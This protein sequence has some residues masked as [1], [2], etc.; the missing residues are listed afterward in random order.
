MTGNEDV[1][2]QIEKQIKMQKAVWYIVLLSFLAFIITILYWFFE[3]DP[4]SVERVAGASTWSKCENRQYSFIRVVKS[5]KAVDIFVQE[6]WHDMDD[7]QDVGTIES[8][9]VISKVIHYPLDAGFEKAMTFNKVVPINVPIGRYEYRPYA[10]Y[11]V[12][13]L[14]RVTKPLPI[15]N[16]DVVCDYDKDKH[17]EVY[18]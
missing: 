9:L 3:P 15:Q 6:R 14:K 1:V 11:Q 8:E 10:S 7:M 12:N 18:R 5:S 17:A 16:V 4:V 13:P 2:K